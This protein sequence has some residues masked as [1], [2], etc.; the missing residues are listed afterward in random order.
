[1]R[2][3]L[4]IGCARGADREAGE[5][6]RSPIGAHRHPARTVNFMDTLMRHFL[7]GAVGGLAFSVVTLPGG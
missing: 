7:S 5:H 6:R 1:M 3:G 4:G 2:R